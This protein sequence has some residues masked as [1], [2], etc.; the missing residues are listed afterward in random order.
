MSIHDYPDSGHR[1]YDHNYSALSDGIDRSSVL[2]DQ[3]KRSDPSNLAGDYHLFFGS[4]AK[5]SS[6]DIPRRSRTGEFPIV[7]IA[8][9]FI[10][11]ML[12]AI[13][14]ALFL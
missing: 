8:A 6:I 9:M 5:Q 10:L 2:A 14:F 12:G 13:I 7:Q 11:G 1:S 4:S 3:H